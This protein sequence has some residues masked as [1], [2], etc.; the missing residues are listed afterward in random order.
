[1]VALVGSKTDDEGNVYDW[2]EID[3]HYRYTDKTRPIAEKVEEQRIGF[4]DALCEQDAAV[5]ERLTLIEDAICE[6]DE[7]ING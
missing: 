7:A 5:D 6:L 4:E 3:Q 2:Y 1:M